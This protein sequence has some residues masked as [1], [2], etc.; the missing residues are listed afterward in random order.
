MILFPHTYI[1]YLLSFDNEILISFISRKKKLRFKYHCDPIFCLNYF[2]FLLDTCFPHFLVK[3][4]CVH[5]NET[6]FF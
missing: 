4:F 3:Y 1:V 2:V 6:G 5:V